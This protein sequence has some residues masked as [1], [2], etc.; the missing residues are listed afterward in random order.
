[1]SMASYFYLPLSIIEWFAYLRFYFFVNLSLYFLNML[2]CF[3]RSILVWNS[4]FWSFCPSVYR[5]L[6]FCSKSYCFWSFIDYLYY[7]IDSLFLLFCGSAFPIFAGFDTFNLFLYK[8]SIVVWF[9]SNI[10]LIEQQFLQFSS[11]DGG[12]WHEID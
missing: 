4:F 3:K 6:S 8:S 11:W 5:F 9:L 2:S 12:S 1:M 10:S 7:C